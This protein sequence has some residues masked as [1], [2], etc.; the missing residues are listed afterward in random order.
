MRSSRLDLSS[1]LQVSYVFGDP[2]KTKFDPSGADETLSKVMRNAWTAFAA[3]H[4]PNRN[5][6]PYWP[7]YRSD[8]SFMSLAINASVA[9]PDTYRQ[10]GIDIWIQ[11]RIVGCSG[12]SNP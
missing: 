10:E 3:N 6:V 2:T 4:N 1:H 12:L 7:D 8:M 11:E 9:Q 5:G